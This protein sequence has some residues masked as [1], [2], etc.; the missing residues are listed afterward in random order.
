M[1]YAITVATGAAKIVRK[2]IGG[3]TDPARRTRGALADSSPCEEVRPA[4][5]I[6]G[7]GKADVLISISVGSTGRRAAPG[8]SPHISDNSTSVESAHR[9][10]FQPGGFS[11][12]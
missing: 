10:I 11:A 12:I 2:R 8:T 3:A 6:G 5:F 4:S 7:S 9:P 1:P